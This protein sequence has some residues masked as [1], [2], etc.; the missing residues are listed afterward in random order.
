MTQTCEVLKAKSEFIIVP[1]DDDLDIL[2][3]DVDQFGVKRI[4]SVLL[5]LAVLRYPREERE[6][7]ADSPGQAETETEVYEEVTP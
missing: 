7:P 4:A 5:I 2:L 1:T 3:A 6:E